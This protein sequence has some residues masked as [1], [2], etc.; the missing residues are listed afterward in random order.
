MQGGG[1]LVNLSQ[2]HLQTQFSPYQDVSEEE[3]LF[4]LSNAEIHIR[5]KR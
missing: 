5:A 2:L 4:N 3:M 1:D